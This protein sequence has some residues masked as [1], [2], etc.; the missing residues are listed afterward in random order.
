MGATGAMAKPTRI[1]LPIAGEGVLAL[2]DLVGDLSHGV[3]DVGHVDQ[4]EVRMRCL[5]G[6]PVEQ[7]IQP[8]QGLKLLDPRRQGIIVA[9]V[10]PMSTTVS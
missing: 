5:L 8:F 2:L 3:G 7:R 6:S 10:Q 9:D 1:E 4:P